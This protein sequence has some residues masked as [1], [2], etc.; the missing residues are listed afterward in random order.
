MSNTWPAWMRAKWL[1]IY[2]SLINKNQKM[3]QIVVCL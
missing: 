3:K 2:L 1:E